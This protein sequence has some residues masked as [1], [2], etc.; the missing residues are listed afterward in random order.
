MPQIPNATVHLD[1]HGPF[2]SM[3]TTNLSSH[4]P[5]RPPRSRFSKLSNQNQSRLWPIPSSPIGSAAWP[6]RRS[7]TLTWTN[8]TP[9][10]S[11]PSSTTFCNKKLP[12]THSST[13]IVD[14]ARIKKPPTSLPKLS[15]G[16]NSA[17]RTSY[18]PSIW[19]TTPPTSRPSHPRHSRSSTATHQD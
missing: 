7:S 6:S 11:K 17:G 3:V 12:T 1:I 9:T 4:S 2:V 19:R 5:T 10:T 15:Q 14:P 13:S 16:Q 8:N 18:Q